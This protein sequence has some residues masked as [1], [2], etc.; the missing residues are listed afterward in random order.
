MFKSFLFFTLLTLCV[1]NVSASRFKQ[2]T[3]WQSTL[4][5]IVKDQPF[6]MIGKATFSILFWDVYNSK[7]LTTSGKFPMQ[8]N[9]ETLIYKIEYLKNATAEELITHTIEQWQH[10]EVTAQNYQPFLPKLSKI[11]PDIKS[12]DSLALVM[13]QQSS[14][15]YYNNKLVGSIDDPKF[16]PLFLDIWLS[17]KTSEPALRQQLLGNIKDD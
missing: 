8:S 10:L 5:G 15:F 11:W 16:G 12:G 1:S 7:L 14:A 6:T 17:E 2:A 3:E 9:N 13:T 4:N